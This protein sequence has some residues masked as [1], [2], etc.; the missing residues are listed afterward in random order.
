MPHEKRDMYP[1]LQPVFQR[2]VDRKFDFEVSGTEH[3]LMDN[4]V[5]V[6]ANH[7]R[8]IDS[9]LFA[10]AYTEATGRPARIGAKKGYFEGTGTDDQG[11][12]GRS[13]RYL[14][15]STRMIS[16]DRKNTDNPKVLRELQDEIGDRLEDEDSVVFHAEGT[17]SL[18]GRQYKFRTGSAYFAM[19]Y[20][21]GLQPAG[22]TYDDH[23]R[24][25]KTHVKVSFG[26]PITPEDYARPPYSDL[27]SR[28]ERA[29]LLT[30]VLEDRVARLTG[31]ERAYEYAPLPNK[32]E[33]SE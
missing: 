23:D 32:V 20:R 15:M 14:V 26:V 28:G 29:N 5:I 24:G 10:T 18:D 13:M 30:Q 3:I 33:T 12:W 1:L 27:K 2:W 6:V 9:A 8:A 16:I 11:K 4:P 7:L 19:R 17:R 22:V 31:A 21:V 25:R